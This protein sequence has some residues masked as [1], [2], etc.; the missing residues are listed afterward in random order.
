MQLNKNK[1]IAKALEVA[2]KA[3]Y[4]DMR[5]GKE[6]TPYIIHPVEVAMILQEN[7]TK[8]EVIAAALL[9]DTLEDTDLT[10]EELKG[11][12]NSRI[13][14]MVIGASEELEDREST[15]W[16]ERKEHTINYLKTIN[17]IDIKYIAC[18]D[19][20]A[21]IRSMIRDYDEIGDELWTI[22]NRGYKKQKWYYESLVDSL[23]QLEG[24]KMYEQF[25]LAVKYLFAHKEVNA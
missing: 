7:G 22:F 2:A 15:P 9:H 11:I 21:N 18:A 23:N 5:K 20:L 1:L 13:T 25:K 19:K 14:E 10:E 16:E 6:D 12:F 17:D 3:H 8:E 4:G 24:V